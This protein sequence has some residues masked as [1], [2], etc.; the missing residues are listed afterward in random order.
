MV[1]SLKS[2]HSILKNESFNS[3]TVNIDSPEFI[4]YEFDESLQPLELSEKDL[5]ILKKQHNIDCSDKVYQIDF[6]FKKDEL[7]KYFTDNVKITDDTWQQV[8]GNHI[9]I[10]MRSVYCNHVKIEKNTIGHSSITEYSSPNK[11]FLLAFSCLRFT[12]DKHG[13]LVNPIWAH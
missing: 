13:N 10:V 5:Q 2:F 12:L 7:I 11:P 6:S 8:F 1:L 3:Q 4:K 9:W